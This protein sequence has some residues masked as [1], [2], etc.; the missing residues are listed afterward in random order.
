MRQDTSII[1]EKY[2]KFKAGL[3]AVPR[4]GFYLAGCYPKPENKFFDITRGESDLEHVAGTVFLTKLIV[5]F[6]PEI[7]PFWQYGDYV[8]V[9]LLHEIGEIETGDIPDDGTRD[10]EKKDAEE[11]ESLAEYL[12]GFQSKN[13]LN[14][15]REL[16][17]RSR[18]R[19]ENLYMIDKLDAI[20]QGLIFEMNGHG[21]TL[22]VKKTVVGTLSERDRKLSEMVGTGDLVDIFAASFLLET[23]VI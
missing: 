14:I 1:W 16:Q 15:F 19:G 3:S 22:G 5:D 2:V 9:L 10:N 13:S 17:Q 23:A 7:I 12:T 4:T 21:G 20:F 6:F 8:S 11:F 18:I